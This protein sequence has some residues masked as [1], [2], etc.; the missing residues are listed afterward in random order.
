VGVEKRDSCYEGRTHV[1]ESPEIPGRL[2]GAVN[3]ETDVPAG[4]SMA[5]ANGSR[6]QCPQQE[7]LQEITAPEKATFDPQLPSTMACFSRRVSI[8]MTFSR[9]RK[10]RTYEGSWAGRGRKSTGW[11]LHTLSPCRTYPLSPF[12]SNSRIAKAKSFRATGF[13]S[14]FRIPSSEAVSSSIISP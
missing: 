1:T 7:R 9:H 2:T 13:D 6:I 14:L 3:D 11:G 4:R 12:P 8:V 10:P 5:C